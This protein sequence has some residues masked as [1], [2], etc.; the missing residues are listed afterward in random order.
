MNAD[1]SRRL[2]GGKSPAPM[3]WHPLPH[4]DE[5]L[6]E[7]AGEAFSDG[8]IR[9]AKVGL[10]HFAAFAATQQIKHPDEITRHH[11]L[12]FQT[13]LTE[14]RKRNGDPLALTYRHALMR[15][16]RNWL[17]W[18]EQVE[19]IEKSPWARIKIGR[20][21]KRPQPL[22]DDELAQLFA[23]HRQSVFAIPPFYY[24]RREAM[25]VLLYGW[26]LRL[27]ELQNLTVEALD[28]RLDYV[29]IPSKGHQG[30]RSSRKTLPYGQE[31]KQVVQRWLRVRATHA[32]LGESA[33]FID[34]YGRPL[35]G[36][37]IRASIAE[38]SHSA[39]VRANPNRLR[40]TFATTMLNKDVPIEQVMKMMGHTD[41][42][43]TLAYSRD[44]DLQVRES[45][46]R[47]VDPLI[48]RLLRGQL[49]S[50]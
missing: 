39:G 37:S 7:L 44:R 49:P 19:H 41:R 3:P 4:M 36:H 2:F 42:S 11:I 5:W 30:T 16:L 50:L 35:S 21:D 32:I 17:N 27:H 10:A 18:L 24:H 48:Q 13:Y 38:L 23:T 22:D 20:V 34:R 31:L 33:L 8:Y 14:I 43:Q 45:H 26:G 25:L 12:R 1:Q 15:Y 9:P 40:D 47:V 6:D 46:D 29:T 28:V